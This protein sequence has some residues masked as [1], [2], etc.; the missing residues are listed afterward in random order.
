MVAAGGAACA[1]GA[2]WAPEAAWV[3]A[4]VCAPAVGVPAAVDDIEAPVT[5]GVGWPTCAPAAAGDSAADALAVAVAAAGVPAEAEGPQVR[6]A[7]FAK[8]STATA[9]SSATN[10]G[11]S[12]ACDMAVAK[13]VFRASGSAPVWPVEPAATGSSAVRRACIRAAIAALPMTAPT[14]RVVL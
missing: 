9:P 8:K 3:P 7:G 6:A 4:A 11:N 13:P 5:A 2:A 10:A 14:W 12:S 1:P